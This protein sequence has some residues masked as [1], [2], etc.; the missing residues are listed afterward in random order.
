[1][2]GEHG[3]KAPTTG[4]FAFVGNGFIHSEKPYYGDFLLEM[5]TVLLIRHALRATFPAGEGLR[6]HTQ[7]RPYLIKVKGNIMFI[8][9]LIKRRN[10]YILVLLDSRL[11]SVCINTII[12]KIRLGRKSLLV[13]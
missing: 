13:W 6:A 9:L 10:W 3:G 1:M 11:S 8:L 12:L 2:A 5:V 7:V 4:E